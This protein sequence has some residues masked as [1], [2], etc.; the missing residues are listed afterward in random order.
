MLILSVRLYITSLSLSFL[1]SS[2]A[3]TQGSVSSIY[4]L[5][6]LNRLKISVMASATWSPS[7]LDS[8]A[9]FV[10]LTTETRSS[11]TLSL[12]PVL[13]TTPSK[14][15]FV[16]DIVLFTR[17]PKTLARSEL[18]LSTTSS[19]VITPSFSKGIS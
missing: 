11:S 6:R 3:S 10:A 18:I 16:I 8:T 2:F 4:L 19:Q 14:Y 7:I 15:L 5:Q 13:S 1:A 12:T 17:F 9:A